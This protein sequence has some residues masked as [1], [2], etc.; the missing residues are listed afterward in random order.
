[1]DQKIVIIVYVILITLF[2]IAGQ[3]TMFI[4]FD[5]SNAKA[6]VFVTNKS[7]ESKEHVCLLIKNYGFLLLTF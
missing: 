6:V 7:Y 5:K 1:M 4:Y 3:V 2:L